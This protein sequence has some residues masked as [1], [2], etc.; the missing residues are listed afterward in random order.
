VRGGLRCEGA[1]LPLLMCIGRK[2]FVDGD[3]FFERSSRQSLCPL[4]EKG[5]VWPA[6]C[7]VD[8][9]NHFRLLSK[10]LLLYNCLVKHAFMETD[11]RLQH[12]GTLFA[13]FM[14]LSYACKKRLAIPTHTGGIC[15]RRPAYLFQSVIG[16][17]GFYVF[18]YRRVSS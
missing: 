7:G 16:L 9:A 1:W 4:D 6:T 13:V 18:I 10:A 12:T 2:W 8:R 17:L 14:T 5:K 15:L 11:S 3:Y